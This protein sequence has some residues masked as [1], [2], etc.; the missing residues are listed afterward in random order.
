MESGFLTEEQL[1]QALAE[2]K[3]A[4]MK[5]GQ[6]ISRQG[7]IKEE[8]IMEILSRQLKVDKYRPDRY[9][10]DMNLSR[11]IPIETARK[12]QVAPLRKKGRLLTIA[13][14]DPLDINALDTTEAL[15][16]H[17]VEPVICTEREFDWLIEMLFHTAGSD[18]RNVPAKDTQIKKRLG[19]ML[20]ESRL[21]TEE[22]LRQALMEHKKAS[23]KLGQYIIRQKIVNEKQIIDILSRQLRIDKYRPDR[24][25]IDMNLAQ[26]IPVETAQKFQVA[27]LQRKGRLLTIVMA[28][29]LDINALDTI[30][31]LTNSEVE[32][33]ICTEG[34]FNQLLERLYG[35]SHSDPWGLSAL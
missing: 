24:Y 34:E 2:H 10:I 25:P 28:D 3:N 14:V 30:E 19:E 17:E 13:M 7:I 26:L 6:Y 15:T 20:V 9:P 21:L 12:F 32:P 35:V 11:M 8:H 4:G 1:G 22:Q 27:P 23:M 18:P 33:I 16:N 5:L 31:A 29:P